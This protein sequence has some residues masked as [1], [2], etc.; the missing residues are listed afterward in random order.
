MCYSPICVDASIQTDDV[1]ADGVSVHMAQ[2][3]VGGVG[4]ERVSG[5]SGQRHYRARSTAVQFSATPRMHRGKDGR[6][7]HLCG[8]GITHLV[9][10]HVQRH[11]GPSKPRKKKELAP[12]SKF[13]WRRK[14]APSAVSSQAGREGGC[15]VEGKQDLKTAR[16]CHV[17]I[18]SP[19]PE[20][21]HALG[22]TLLEEG[23]R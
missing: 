8:P 3:R 9:Q 7:R 20:D 1:C 4:G 21:P 19:F 18:T 23:E 5:D 14:E 12:K 11:K 13:I 10:G 17:H 16:T 2:M 15:G 22:T 6:V